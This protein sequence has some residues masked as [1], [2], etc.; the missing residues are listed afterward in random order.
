MSNNKLAKSLRSLVN[1]RLLQRKANSHKGDYGRVLIVAG[2]QGMTGA[3]VLASRGALR[4]GAGLTY[5]AVPKLLVNHVDSMTPEVITLSID[6]INKILPDAIAI[7]PGLGTSKTTKKM[8]Q[9]LFPCAVPTIID[10]DGI[11]ILASDLGLLRKQKDY[12]QAPVILTPHP[13]EMARLMGRRISI[14][15]KH[16]EKLAKSFAKEYGCIVVLKGNK[17]VVAN[18][19][20]ECYVNTSGNPGMACGGVGDVLTG[21][22]AGLLAQAFSPWDAAVTAVYLHGL[23]GDLAAKEKT[24]AGMTASDLV[25]KIPDAISKSG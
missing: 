10:A 9:T 20:G 23:A 18:S 17:T 2:S 5:L 14:I 8:F 7:G 24:M 15:Q 21:L 3:A 12:P 19:S 22:M 6:K 11:N 13:G 1:D 4:S 25:E 16:R